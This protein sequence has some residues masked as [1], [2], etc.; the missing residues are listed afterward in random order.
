MRISL[1]ILA[2]S[3]VLF[4]FG[5]IGLLGTWAVVTGTVLGLV[6]GVVLVI[7]LEDR[8]RASAGMG[9]LVQHR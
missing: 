9:A 3:T 4:L 7:T 1:G 5:A 2:S 6:G 8:E